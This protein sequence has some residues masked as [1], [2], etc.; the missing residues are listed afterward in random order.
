MVALCLD[1][2]GPKASSTNAYTRAGTAGGANVGVSTRGS[3][4][5]SG[6]TTSSVQ[7][8]VQGATGTAV[9]KWQALM[10]LITWVHFIQ[11][12]PLASGPLAGLF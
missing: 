10:L 8:L 5:G 7:A 3:T 1:A 11:P 6:S 12:W 9:G 4:I 2:A